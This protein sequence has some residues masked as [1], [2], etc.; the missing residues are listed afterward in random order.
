MTTPPYD[1]I[2]SHLLEWKR[3]DD[4]AVGRLMNI[5]D[6]FIVFCCNNSAR[7]REALEILIH[8]ARQESFGKDYRGHD[9]D[10]KDCS[11]GSCKADTVLAQVS[12]LLEGESK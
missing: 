2:K 3:I 11:C 7:H 6:Q 1:K 5:N 12:K 10:R 4:A 8:F 9:V